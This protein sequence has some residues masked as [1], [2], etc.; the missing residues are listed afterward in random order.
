MTGWL[1]N[2]SIAILHCSILQ[3]ERSLLASRSTSNIASRIPAH[4]VAVKVTRS[5]DARRNTIVIV[6]LLAIP[7]GLTALLGVF[8]RSCL[9]EGWKCLVHTI[10]LSKS[11]CH[12]LDLR[13][14][15]L[16]DVIK[17]WRELTWRRRRRRRPKFSAKFFGYTVV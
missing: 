8:Q 2:L 1:C 5:I 9:K 13:G 12:F 3:S 4:P 10:P 7:P 14:S 11:M 17:Y 15:R 16:Y 6:G